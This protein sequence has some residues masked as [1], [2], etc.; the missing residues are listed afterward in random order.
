MTS[1]RP[2]F[3][4]SPALSSAFS[5]IELLTVVGLM[6]LMMTVA[7]PALSSLSKS[8][9][10][11]NAGDLLWGQLNLARQ[12]SISRNV[13]TAAVIL[14]SD[15]SSGCRT[16]ALF[17]Y[18]SGPDRSGGWAQISKWETIPEGVVVDPASSFFTERPAFAPALDSVA[19]RGRSVAEE[20]LAVQVFSPTGALVGAAG[21]PTI[22]IVEGSLAGGDAI[23]RTRRAGGASAN[24]YRIT[25][26]NSTGRLK[27]ERVPGA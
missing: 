23:N 24:C 20:N 14:K 3:R 10:L 22:E 6:G 5:L 21:A 13:L 16:V 19:Y 12:N 11:T 9:S 18:P 25:I 27:T 26:I 15:A 7:M 2:A 8:S 4:N 17:Q 1:P